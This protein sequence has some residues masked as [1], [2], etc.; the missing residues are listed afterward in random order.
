MELQTHCVAELSPAAV[1]H[2]DRRGANMLARSGSGGQ[3]TV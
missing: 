3:L 2:P 1:G